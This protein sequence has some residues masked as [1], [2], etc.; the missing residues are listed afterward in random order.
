MGGAW[1]L[2]TVAQISETKVGPPTRGSGNSVFC[3][4]GENGVLTNEDL[5]LFRLGDA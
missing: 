3:R 4:D 1:L 5:D 2:F